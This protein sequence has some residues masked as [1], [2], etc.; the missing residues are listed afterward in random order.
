MHIWVQQV[1]TGEPVRLTRDEANEDYPA[2]SPDGT[3]IASRSDREGGGIY[4]VSLLGGQP[5]LLAAQG[6]RPRYSPDGRLILFIPQGVQLEVWEAASQE[7]LIPAEGG[8]RR[9]VQIPFRWVR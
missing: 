2:F 9:L 5:R 4:V 6:T 7:F 8:E 1:P 3:K